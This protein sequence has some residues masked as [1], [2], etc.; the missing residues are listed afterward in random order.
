MTKDQA[1]TLDE[2]RKKVR[3]GLDAW[4]NPDDRI[5]WS[6]IDGVTEA[7]VMNC[8]GEDTDASARIYDT[9]VGIPYVVFNGNTLDKQKRVELGEKID[10]KRCGGK[11]PLEPCDS[12]DTILM[13]Y[14]C[15]GEAYLGAVNHCLV[16][17]I[18]PDI[19]GGKKND[20]S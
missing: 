1:D 17:E 3:D 10:C 12:G 6:I 11:H 19:S 20:D 7:I 2:A 8:Y 9:S 5:D 13:F 15:D 18:K 16:S 4:M 14:R